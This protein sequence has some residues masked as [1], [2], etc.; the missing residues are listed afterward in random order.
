MFLVRS[1]LSITTYIFLVFYRSTSL[2]SRSFLKNI[3]TFLC[4][5]K[6][7]NNRS[8]PSNQQPQNHDT[9][10]KKLRPFTTIHLRSFLKNIKNFICKQKIVNNCSIPSTHA[11]KKITYLSDQHSFTLHPSLSPYRQNYRQRNEY[12]CCAWAGGFFFPVVLVCQFSVLAGNRF[13]FYLLCTYVLRVQYS[14]GV[15]LV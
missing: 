5:Q 15:V 10:S 2:Q 8:I 1:K 3:K 9:F 7:V 6:L 11:V 12:T 14:C 4:K 13:Q